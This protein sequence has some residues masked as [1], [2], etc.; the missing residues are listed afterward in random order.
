MGSSRLRTFASASIAAMVAAKLTASVPPRRLKSLLPRAETVKR[1]SD[2]R[3]PRA[4][5]AKTLAQGMPS[6]ADPSLS[7]RL[8]ALWEHFGLGAAFVATQMPIDLGELAACYPERIAGAVFCT[9]NRL[10][11]QPFAAIADRLL[12]IA[13]ERGLTAGTTARAAARLPGAERF[14]LADYDALGWSDVIA[15]RTS[16][17]ANR[18][19]EFLHGRRA[20]TPKPL[21]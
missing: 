15:D 16:E 3:P 19:L 17:I 11:P 1:R 7:D 20:D 14:V 9:P 4:A 6:S 18:M 8:I 13:S 10:D 5:H 2:D 21:G 12:L